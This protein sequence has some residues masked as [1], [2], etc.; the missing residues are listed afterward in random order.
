[1]AVSSCIF[2]RTVGGFCF[3]PAQVKGYKVEQVASLG[4]E[5]EVWAQGATEG[6]VAQAIIYNLIV[7]QEDRATTCIGK[8]YIYV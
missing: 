6:G 8:L 3:L 5:E 2:Q 7:V 1:M 4:C